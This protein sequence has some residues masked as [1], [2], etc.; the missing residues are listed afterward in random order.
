MMFRCITDKRRFPASEPAS[1]YINK[2]VSYQHAT[3]N[4]LVITT[5]LQVCRPLIWSGPPYSILLLHISPLTSHMSNTHEVLCKTSSYSSSCTSGRNTFTVP[6]ANRQLRSR[7]TMQ[8]VVPAIGE[9]TEKQSTVTVHVI[10]PLHLILD[11][12]ISKFQAY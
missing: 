4:P 5:V 7:Q 1:A 10:R 2:F 8:K 11:A 12:L 9:Y 6:K 3:K